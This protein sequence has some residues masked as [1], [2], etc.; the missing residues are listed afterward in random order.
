[1]TIAITPEQLALRDAV[2]D[3]AERAAPRVVARQSADGARDG[4]P[5]RDL[6]AGWA[7]LTD[8]G[9]FGI[10][11]PESHGGAGHGVDDLAVAVEELGYALAPEPF[12]PTA[13]AALC[14][15]TDADSPVAKAL[16]PELAE[17]T[18]AAVSLGDGAVLGAGPAKYLL[19]PA[20]TGYQVVE[21]DSATVTPVRGTDPTR[22]IATV[23][24]DNES[25]RTLPHLTVERV[26]DLAATLAAAE[27]A[28]IAGWAT[29][30]AVAYAKTRE[31]FGRT[32]GSFQSIKHLCADMLART[33]LAKAAAWDAAIAVDDDEHPLTAAV[34]AVVAIDAAVDCAKDCIQVL[35]GIGFTWEHDAHLALRRALTLRSLLGT[36]GAWRQ[37]VTALT[38]A[39][40]V[41]HLHLDLADH[42]ESAAAERAA[43]RAALDEVA[44]L[45]PA[46]QRRRLAPTGFLA[47]HWPKPWG[48]DA[49]AAE[50]LAIAEEF[51][52]A[53]VKQPD[54]VIGTWAVPTI[55]AHGTD[56]QREKFV[57]PTL[58]G[59]I[60]WCQMFSEPGAGSDLA[61]LRTRATKVEGG[62]RLDG[63]KVWTSL[64]QI[65]HWAICLARTNP[66]A[67]NH[68]GI[69]YFLVD[70]KTP[71]I[72][73]RPLR[74]ISGHA[75][76]NEIFLDDVFVPDD[77]VVG[78]VDRGWVLART[79]LANERVGMASGPTMGG[80]VENLLKVVEQ[81]GYGDD[82][83]VTD[84]LGDLI[85]RG[86]AQA[87]LGLRATLR[88]LSGTDP[89]A[90]SSVRKLVGMHHTQDVRELALEL[91]GPAGAVEEGDAVG[92]ILGFLLTRQLTIAGGTSQV[93][94][95]VIGERIL[96]LPRDV[97]A[98]K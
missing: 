96:G 50:Q 93:L 82:A 60:I 84:K 35:G 53:G 15:L 83:A 23:S 59:D 4:I 95:N 3:W 44:G 76:F 30:T 12:W 36:T 28:G 52:S 17:G 94:R 6:P 18:P 77:M 81:T 67:E 29:D 49:G 37:R 66:E 61:S 88:Q 85:A 63:Q 8:L 1:M 68:A 78:D 73:V 42:E 25:D 86:Q 34:A 80:G 56:A 89:G 22:A 54:L 13:L 43:A 40:V 21:A 11:I 71:G 9:L 33:E 46:E 98:S 20:A 24:H 58:A 51:K 38:R 62:W 97:G 55:I 31:Q 26:R 32:I 69:T 10:A 74:E 19:L 5:T 16:L 92:Q 75:Q 45:D 72:D 79:T 47:P 14:L 48:R 57:V 87:V 90:M 7:Q 41:R 39:G 27:A 70:M 65:A 91:L 2:R 64:A